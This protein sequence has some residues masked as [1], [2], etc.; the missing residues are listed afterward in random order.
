MMNSGRKN[1]FLYG[2]MAGW[3]HA[4][5]PELFPKKAMA[6]ARNG[7]AK[8]IV[9]LYSPVFGCI[10]KQLNTGNLH[11]LILLKINSNYRPD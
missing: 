7:V 11:V 8:H 10:G 1:C 9:Q 3:H 4:S 2:V 6:T 5:N